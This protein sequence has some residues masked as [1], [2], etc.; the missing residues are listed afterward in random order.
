MRDYYEELWRELPDPLRP[1]DRAL[2]VA[3][4][5]AHV[6]AG[7]RVLDL[8]CGDGW[9]CGELAAL[10]A[11]PLG[12][13]IAPAAVQRARRHHPDLEFRIAE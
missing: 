1:P 7:E 3:F 9:M 5:R 13:E 4:M 11:V 10:G 2:R 8:G 12:V 6:R